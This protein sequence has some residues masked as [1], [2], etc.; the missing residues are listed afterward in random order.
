MNGITVAM[1][2]Q[3]TGYTLI[4]LM[5][6]V[7]IA[8]IVLSLGVPAFTDTLRNNRLT[9]QSN[10]LVT[11]LNLARAEAV[12]R[13]A[14]VT[15]CPSSDQSTCTGSAWQDGWIVRDDG[16]GNVIHYFPAMKGATTVASTAATV[17]YSQRGF[18]SNGNPVTMTLC[19]GSGESGRQITLTGT[20]R[21]SSVT[22][23]PVC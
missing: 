11:A 13:R 15:V 10:D 21:P 9:T 4:E 20:G 2:K 16:S 14:N 1:R 17:S 6:T 3:N 12:K 7:F 22:P 5:M 18:L 23:H 8:A 19:A